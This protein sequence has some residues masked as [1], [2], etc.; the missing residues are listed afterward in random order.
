VAKNKDDELDEEAGD[1]RPSRLVE[2]GQAIRAARLMRGYATQGEL[3]AASGIP[4]AQISRYE[5]GARDMYMATA[6][7]LAQTLNLSV[8]QLLGIAPRPAA[9]REEAEIERDP[10]PNRRRLRGLP[11]YA[12]APAWVK[13]VIE[14]RRGSTGDLTFFEWVDELRVFMAMHARG[15]SLEPLRDGA[16]APTRAKKTDGARAKNRRR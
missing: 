2:Q 7:R 9:K 1:E 11:E 8:D 6:L 10:Y 4:Q 3:S 14:G 5:S 12:L 15:E 16:G 13:A